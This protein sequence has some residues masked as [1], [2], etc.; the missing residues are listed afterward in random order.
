MRVLYCVAHVDC[1]GRLEFCRR[2]SKVLKFKAC[3]GVLRAR[4][5]S[6]R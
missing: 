6:S 4:V 5:V 3:G 1:R 2:G